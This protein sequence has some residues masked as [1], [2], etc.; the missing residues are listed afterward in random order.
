VHSKVPV[1]PTLT[2]LAV[3]IDME[4]NPLFRKATDFMFMAKRI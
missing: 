3:Y 1:S 2:L 4:L